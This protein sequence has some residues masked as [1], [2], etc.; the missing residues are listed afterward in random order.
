MV[1]VMEQLYATSLF[2]M[3]EKLTKGSLLAAQNSPAVEYANFLTKFRQEYYRNH[4][5]GTKVSRIAYL[6]SP[7]I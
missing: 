6:Y 7:L 2:Q 5:N 4:T 1:R 3:D